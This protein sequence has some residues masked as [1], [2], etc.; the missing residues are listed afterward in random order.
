MREVEKPPFEAVGFAAKDGYGLQGRLYLPQADPHTVLLVNS[1]TA[2]PQ[3]FYGRF[4]LFAAEQGFAVLTYD[5]RGIGDSAPDSIAGFQADYRDWGQLDMT[6]AIAWLKSRFPGLPITALGHSTGGQQLGLT[7]HVADIKAA[8]FI[9]VSTGYWKGCAFKM[10]WLSI[11]LW[12]VL[13][14][15]STRLLGYAPT[16]KLGLGEDLPS[17][18]IKEW[19]AWCL[20]P[21]YMAAYFDETGHRLS[22]NG[23]PFGQQRFQEIAFPIKAYYFTDDDIATA[24]NVPAMLK[25]YET[26]DVTTEWIEPADINQR[27]IGHLGFFRK[28]IAESLWQEPLAWLKEKAARQELDTLSRD[29][30]GAPS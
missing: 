4:A 17:G 16:S 18:V 30:V 12:K 13:V 2:I 24:A 14:P 1:G 29:Q 22:V 5:Y 26:T 21:A 7:D 15:I 25:L 28:H 9:A 27:A 6:G 20:D 3:G 19:G 10:K 23:K 8:I 11:W